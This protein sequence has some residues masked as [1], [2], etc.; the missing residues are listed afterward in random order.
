MCDEMLSVLSSPS[1][2]TLPLKRGW[3]TKNVV[4]SRKCKMA[5]AQPPMSKWMHHK[6]SVLHWSKHVNYVIWDTATVLDNDDHI[7][8]Y[9]ILNMPSSCIFYS[10]VS[11]PFSKLPWVQSISLLT[12]TCIANESANDQKHQIIPHKMKPGFKLHTP[13][14]HTIHSRTH[15]QGTSHAG[16][17]FHSI[18]S[19]SVQ[20]KTA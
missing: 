2:C 9:V 12:R 20:S 18:I 19:M 16:T 8:M 6:I 15:S 1:V 17:V 5:D 13:R 10:A 3:K 14:T 11:P 4:T 7:S